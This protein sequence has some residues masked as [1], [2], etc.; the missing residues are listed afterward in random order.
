MDIVVYVHGKGGSAA[1]AEHYRAFFPDAKVLGLDYQTF[2]PWE[3]GNEI[4][5]IVRDLYEKYDNVVLIA[6]SIGAFFSMCG[7]I[8]AYVKQAYF[9]S[10]VVDMEM[11]ITNMMQWAQV[12]EKDLEEQGVIPTEFGE[13]LS[14]EYLSYV[15][16]HPIQWTVPTQILYGGHDNL[17]D[18]V[19]MQ[20]FA[21]NHDA[22][23]TVME[24]GEHW[25]HTEEQRQF[26]DDWLWRVKGM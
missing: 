21:D 1:E 26:L 3:T 4:R 6:N 17:T 18:Y 14:W 24:A 19:T 12:T 11:L 5:E 23:L 2:T 8:D 22:D 16:S 7:G 15:R 9:I 13:D 10:P 20:A 25:F